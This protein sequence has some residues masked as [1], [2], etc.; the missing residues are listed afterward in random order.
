[1]LSQGVHVSQVADGFS[2]TVASSMAW[3]PTI[4]LVGLGYVGLPLALE[5]GKTQWAPVIGYNKSSRRVEALRQ[6]IDPT[7]EMSSEEL[8][9]SVVDYTTDPEALRKSNFIIVT[10]PTPITAAKQPDLTPVRQASQI[11]GEHLSKDTIVVFE[12]TV[13]PGVTEEICIPI[14]EKASGLH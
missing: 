11:I 10:V 13:Y 7:G 2:P 4:A 3:K 8:R 12:S 1:M 9:I 14:I 5:F 6:G